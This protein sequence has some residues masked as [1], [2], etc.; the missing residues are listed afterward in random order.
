MF[1]TNWSRIGQ[2]VRADAGTTANARMTHLDAK[3]AGARGRVGASPQ[4]AHAQVDELS[5]QERK[6]TPSEFRRSGARRSGV[7]RNG[8][9]HI[10]KT[11]LQRFIAHGGPDVRHV[12]SKYTTTPPHN[13]S[14]RIISERCRHSDGTTTRA[15]EGRPFPVKTTHTFREKCI[16]LLMKHPCEPA[17]RKRAAPT[18]NGHPA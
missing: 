17:S 14:G 5:L 8:V 11:C 12:G 7:A 3:P 1:G 2:Q 9:D 15:M 10:P 18:R 16:A 13:R 4:P 6:C